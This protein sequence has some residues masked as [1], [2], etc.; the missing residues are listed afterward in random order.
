MQFKRRDSLISALLS[1]TLLCGLLEARADAQTRIEVTPMIN[2]S[3]TYDDNIF[4]A[5]DNKVSDYITVVTPGIALGLVQ[6]HTNFQVRYAPSFYRYADRDDQDNTAHSAGL[7]FGQDLV[8]GLRFNLTDTFLKSEDPLED[9]QNLQ[10]IRQTRNKYV[11]NVADANLG[12]IF[13]AENRVNVGYRY[14]YYEND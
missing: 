3:E 7:T 4:L 11:T 14:N 2:V 6:E 10:G 5:K 1:L 13:G 12:Y 8:E 9:P